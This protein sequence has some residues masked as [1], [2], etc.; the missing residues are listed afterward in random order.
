MR[1]PRRWHTKDGII[2]PLSSA[3]LKAQKPKKRAKVLLFFQMTK[4]FVK[5]IYKKVIMI[6][7]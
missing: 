3:T 4:T 2:R 6:D 1:S 5:K 7:F